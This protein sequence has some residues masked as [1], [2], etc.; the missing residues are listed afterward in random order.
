VIHGDADPLVPV[1]CGIDVARSV[2]DAR[3]E[4]IEGMGHAL[5]IR[6]WPRIVEA[7]SEHAAW[8]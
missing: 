7:I 6:L 3:L 1:A 4:V 2:P 8:T 5:P